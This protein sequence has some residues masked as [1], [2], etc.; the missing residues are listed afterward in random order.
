MKFIITLLFCVL[1]SGHTEV[2]LSPKH[3][4]IITIEKIVP[5]QDTKEINCLTNAIFREAGNQPQNGKKAIASVVFNRMEKN[6]KTVCGTVYE[7]GQFSFTKNH[8]KIKDYNNWFK[9]YLLAQ[10]FISEYNDYSWED[11]VA[12][13]TYYHTKNS[14]PF[15]C[16]S[17][18]VVK[19]AKI[20]DH[21]F[22]K[23][24]K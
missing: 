10:I 3:S 5:V 16:K 6:N 11:N 9:T 7:K 8:K 1:I 21:I 12:G 2:E 20:G 17:K 24:K 18:K 13:S 15:W 14:R 22:Y 4:P 19:V 23:D